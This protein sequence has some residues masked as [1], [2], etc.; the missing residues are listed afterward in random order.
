MPE[1][2]VL[3]SQPSPEVFEKL[4]TAL[5]PEYLTDRI[6]AYMPS[7]GANA[8]A[9]AKYNPVWQQFAE[10][11]GA[12]FVFID[13]SKRGE[14]AEIEKQKILS[15]TILL[16]SGGNTF[17]LLDHLN[18]SGLA[19]TVKTFWQKG[20]V[21]LS[22]FSAGAIVLAPRI[23]IASQPSGI[24]PTDMMDENLVGIAD[25][26]GLNILDF[27]VWPHYYP[28]ID[29]KNLEKYQNTSLNKVKP[30]GDDEVIIIDK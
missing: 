30:L 14:E 5:F 22:G 16:I 26:T 29:Q 23:D 24:D 28:D 1:R 7:D 11:N 21:T 25:L 20:G 19:E 8:E 10:S 6:L 3:F 4:K 9:N 12:K 2:L 15:S 17:T 27:E 18:K 13:N